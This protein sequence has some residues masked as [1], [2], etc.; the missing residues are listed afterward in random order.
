VSGRGEERRGEGGG[1]TL[2]ASYSF[3]A[4]LQERGNPYLA[5]TTKLEHAARG[6]AGTFIRRD[7]VLT[8]LRMS[9]LA[10]LTP[11]AL[12]AALHHCRKERRS[13]LS[14]FRQPPVDSCP[15]QSPATAL[16]YRTSLKGF[17]N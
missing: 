11:V 10:G 9:P 17:Q 4:P 6:H 5:A 2:S 1:G 14:G 7:P 3:G 8:H 13:A 16:L 12:N 15:P